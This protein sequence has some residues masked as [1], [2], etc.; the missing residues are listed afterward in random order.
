MSEAGKIT[1]A[2]TVSDTEHA[3]TAGRLAILAGGGQ[4]PATLAKSDPDAFTVSFKG[5]PIDFETAYTASFEKLG[6]LFKRLHKEGVT[7]VVFAGGLARPALNPLRFDATMIRLAPRILAAMKGGDDALLRLVIEVFEAEGFAIVG[8]HDVEPTL[9]ATLG[10]ISGSEPDEQSLQDLARA[11]AILEALADVDVGQ[12]CVVANGLCHGIETIQG[13]DE[14]LRFVARSDLERSGILLKRAKRG[15]ELRV[16][17]P[18]IGPQT[19]KMAHLAG[20]AGICVQAGKVMIVERD[21]VLRL[22]EDY[23]IFLFGEAGP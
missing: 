6:R 20:L 21:E 23:G 13:T 15:Q 1:G 7:R 18:V 5:A 16:D 22:S 19:L 3:A 8:A 11:G 9:L 4:L 2:K 10:V 14:M 17:M 12:G